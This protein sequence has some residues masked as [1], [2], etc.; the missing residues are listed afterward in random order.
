MKAK[1]VFE[2]ISYRNSQQLI[3]DITNLVL[4]YEPKLTKK[5]ILHDIDV[6][7]KQGEGLITPN[8]LSMHVQDEL[9]SDDAI[10]YVTLNKSFNYCSQNLQQEFQINK[11]V[12]IVINPCHKVD[13]LSKLKDFI[14]NTRRVG[15]ENRSKII[16]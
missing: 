10:F 16:F 15:N 3:E 11:L 8:I 5:I 13:H 6:R 9:V 2:K 1:E 14:T 12:L 4:R 7:N